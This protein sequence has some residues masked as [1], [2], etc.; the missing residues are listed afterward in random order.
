M[1]MKLRNKR[2]RDVGEL[3]YADGA[4]KVSY[5]DLLNTKEKITTYYNSLAELNEEWEDYEEPK[6]AFEI[7]G[8]VGGDDTTV[9]IVFPTHLEAE[10]A[11]E[12]LKAWKLLFGGGE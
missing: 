10:K 5:Y 4:S 8:P 7:T 2:T 9:L 11:V 3:E 12:K 1:K 6:E